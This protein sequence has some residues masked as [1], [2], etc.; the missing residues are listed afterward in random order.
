MERKYEDADGQEHTYKVACTLIDD[1]FDFDDDSDF[2]GDDGSKIY[3]NSEVG[4]KDE[5][6]DFGQFE[7]IWDEDDKEIFLFGTSSSSSGLSSW[8]ESCT[9]GSR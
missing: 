1:D 8:T 6:F 3:N 9:L 2:F 4:L 7:L 5:D